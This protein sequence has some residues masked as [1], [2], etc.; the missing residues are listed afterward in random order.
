MALVR[1]EV[2]VRPGVTATLKLE[3]GDDG[4]AFVTSTEAEPEAET[5]S[6]TTAKNKSAGGEA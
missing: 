2:E 3:K 6:R 1:K 5:K 4:S